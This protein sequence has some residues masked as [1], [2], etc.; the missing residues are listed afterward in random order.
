MRYTAGRT[1][2][3]IALWIVL[4][5]LCLLALVALFAPQLAPHDPASIQLSAR[6]L[7]PG[8]GYLFGTDELGRDIFS[9]VLFGARISLGV[10]TTVVAL[11]LVVGMVVGAIAGFYGGWRDTV[12]NLYVMNAFLALPGILLA[13][14]FVAF[15]GPGLRNLIFALALTGW[16]NY[17]RLVRAQV[18]AARER[19]YVEAARSLGAS[20]TRIL[21]RHI[22]PNIAQPIIVQ[23]AIG[24]AAAVLAEATL[25]FLGLGVPPPAASWGSMLNDA[26]AHLFD[27]PYMAAFPAGAVIVTVLAMSFLGDLLRDM[28]DVRG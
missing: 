11:S 18:M 6:L 24:L 3:R 10:A 2:D 8:H 7:P 25:S 28:A 15:L 5:L 19:E 26:R 4:S 13:I 27:A 17:A 14:A 9:R 21:V 16:V 23:S 22:L 12:L 1:S 20:D